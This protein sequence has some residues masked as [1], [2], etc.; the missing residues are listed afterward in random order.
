MK[1]TICASV[2]L[3]G[4]AVG[5]PWLHST[6]SDEPVLSGFSAESSHAERQWEEK[7]KA[8]PSSQLMRDY[9]QRLS[10]RPHN[11]GTP[12]AKDNAEWL[13]AK[14]KEFGLDTHIETFDI[15]NPTPKDRAVGLV[16]G[17]PKSV[18]ET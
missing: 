17:G 5:L 9:M 10:A 14:F 8:I 13:A 7:F 18:G 15:L 2:L 4:V 1:R 3:L 6:S 11:V 12:Y 16:D